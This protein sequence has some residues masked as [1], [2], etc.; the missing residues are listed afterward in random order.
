MTAGA[1]AAL[2]AVIAIWLGG[3]N[4]VA[5]RVI[6]RRHGPLGRPNAIW[7]WRGFFFGPDWMSYSLMVAGAVLVLAGLIW[8]LVV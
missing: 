3:G 2:G 1:L 5:R 6:A 8:A 4:F 7:F